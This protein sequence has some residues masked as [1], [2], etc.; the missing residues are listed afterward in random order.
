MV[1]LVLEAD[2]I[3]YDFSR[4]RFSFEILDIFCFL[5]RSSSALNIWYMWKWVLR[6]HHWKVIQETETPE[7]LR[8]LQRFE[9]NHLR[10]LEKISIFDEFTVLQPKTLLKNEL[11]W[12]LIYI[13][14][15]KIYCSSFSFVASGT[16]K[17]IYQL[18]TFNQNKNHVVHEK[19][20]LIM[21]WVC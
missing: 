4:I 19:N 6:K 21:V 12:T 9:Q 14:L 7:M 1:Y 16:F 18:P 10:I 8:K 13:M 11:K 2:H 15:L 5:S 3:S 20:I 17:W